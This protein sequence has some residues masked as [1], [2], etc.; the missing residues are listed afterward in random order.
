MDK[1]SQHMKTAAVVDALDRAPELVVSLVHEV[2]PNVLK[3]RPM[4]NKWSAHEHACHLAVAHRLFSIGWS[5]CSYH[6]HRSSHH[7]CCLRN[8]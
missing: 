4:R 2:P 7:I 8:A 5:R 3:R 1:A 6:R